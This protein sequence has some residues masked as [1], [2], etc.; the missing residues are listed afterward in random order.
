V[1]SSFV[2]RFGAVAINNQRRV[3]HEDTPV[4]LL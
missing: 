3:A 1:I 2:S 4:L